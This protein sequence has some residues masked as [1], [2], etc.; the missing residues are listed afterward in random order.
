YIPFGSSSPG[1]LN[2]NATAFATQNKSAMPSHLMAYPGKFDHEYPG[3]AEKSRT[4]M[5]RSTIKV[6]QTVMFTTIALETLTRGSSSQRP[7]VKELS[8]SSL[9]SP[10]LAAGITPPFEEADRLTPLASSEKQRELE[11]DRQDNLAEVKA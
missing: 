4:V 1:D 11:M 9:P 6:N 5:K 2:G 8:Y 3:L 10:Q 7:S